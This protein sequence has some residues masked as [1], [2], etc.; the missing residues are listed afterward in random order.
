M[1]YMKENPNSEKRM[2]KDYSGGMMVKYILV[3]GKMIKEK[4]KG[5]IVGM[6]VMFIMVIG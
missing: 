1:E 2:G 4:E 5:N 6:M 3:T